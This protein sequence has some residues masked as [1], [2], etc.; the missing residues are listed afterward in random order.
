M[1]WVV[2]LLASWTFSLVPEKGLVLPL[3]MGHLLIARV[4]IP[5]RN[6]GIGITESIASPLS[7]ALLFTFWLNTSTTGLQHSPFGGCLLQEPHMARFIQ[8][9]FVPS[10]GSNGTLMTP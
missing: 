1:S 10:H 5:I 3:H 2:V 6:A 7:W 8:Y 9:V 4:G